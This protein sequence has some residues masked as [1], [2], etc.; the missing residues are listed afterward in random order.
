MTLRLSPI[1]CFKNIFDSICALLVKWKKRDLQITS[2]TFLIPPLPQAGHHTSLL[3]TAVS[4]LD[5]CSSVQLSPQSQAGNWGDLLPRALPGDRS[6]PIIP[7]PTLPFFL[8]KVKLWAGRL[9]SWVG[10]NLGVAAFQTAWVS[11]ADHFRNSPPLHPYHVLAGLGSGVFT[12]RPLEKRKL[13][14]LGNTCEEP[15]TALQE[16]SLS[17]A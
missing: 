6:K 16:G 15:C 1:Q 12:A 10:E 13:P 7:H 11:K 14:F 17:W 2:H 3:T 4:G 8:S 9:Y 5:P